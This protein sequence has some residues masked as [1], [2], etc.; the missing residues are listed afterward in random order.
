MAM[1]V[2]QRLCVKDY[3]KITTVDF[4]GEF[5]IPV[6]S[7]RPGYGFNIFHFFNLKKDFSFIF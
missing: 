1:L 2:Y 3:D 4:I 7:I 6:S 5:S